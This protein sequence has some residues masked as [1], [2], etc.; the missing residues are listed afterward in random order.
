MTRRLCD[1]CEQPAF[2]PPD[3]AYKITISVSVWLIAREYD[4]C[5]PCAKI[6]DEMFQNFLR[7]KPNDKR[8]ES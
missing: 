4:F 3:T 7:G 5:E 8:S 2:V 6:F 1:R